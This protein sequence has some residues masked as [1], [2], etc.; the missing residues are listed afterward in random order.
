MAN[1]KVEIDQANL[2]D[3]ST[4]VGLVAE[5]TFIGPDAG[6]H[7]RFSQKV[8]VSPSNPRTVTNLPAGP[9][10]VRLVTPSGEVL[11]EAVDLEEEREGKVSFLVM[12]RLVKRGLVRIM[13]TA[14]GEAAAKGGLKLKK[15]RRALYVKSFGG[16]GAGQGRRTT[17]GDAAIAL[18]RTTGEDVSVLRTRPRGNQPV[19]EQDVLGL[20]QSLA[21]GADG[22]VEVEQMVSGHEKEVRSRTGKNKEAFWNL[23]VQPNVLGERI[24]CVV[25][26]QGKTRVHSLPEPW[27]MHDPEPSAVRLELGNEPATGSH[28]SH[29]VIDDEMFAGLLAYMSAGAIVT[30]ADLVKADERFSSL[31][32]VEDLLRQKRF[33]PL[34]ACAAA[35]VLIGSED[36]RNPAPWHGWINNLAAWFPW[37]PDGSILNARLALLKA[38]SEEEGEAVLPLLHK[39]LERGVPYYCIG[40]GWLIQ[41]M[42]HF[43][44][45]P[46]VTKVRP[47]V[48]RV[49]SCLD[50][51]EPFTTFV[52][53]GS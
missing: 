32:R 22:K 21:D 29:V 15:R 40:F 5:L 39:A 8:S 11:S 6:M 12:P 41:T 19:A 42:M 23:Q 46:L 44:D 47:L 20:W 17:Y 1:L 45:D 18:N 48:E 28:Q 34:G 31:D 53:E 38:Q 49:S 2:S 10:E 24:F 9:W 7:R 33:S 52:L 25:P 51:A 37:I 16:T 30:A 36:L 13:T 14:A 4:S 43:P 50:M 35:Y 26:L 27:R 3:R